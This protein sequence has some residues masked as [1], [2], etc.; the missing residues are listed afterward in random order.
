[1]DL[2]Q[3]RTFT[4]VARTG[5]IS[6]AAAQLGYS[7][8]ALSRQIQALEND[9]GVPLLDRVARGIRLTRH[10]EA[11]LPYAREV[12]RTLAQARVAVAEASDS[13]VRVRLGSVPS[14][15]ASLVVPAL[16]LLERAEP[17][18]LVDLRQG[19]AAAL[20]GAVLA[21]E[22]DAAVILAA[23][24]SRPRAGLTVERVL[25]DELRLLV[26]AGH[27]SAE[28]GVPVAL[29]ELA[30]QAW[31]ETDGDLGLLHRVGAEAGLRLPR[32]RPVPDHAARIAYVAGGL[33]L[34][35]IPGLLA[36]DLPAGLV[37]VALRDAPRRD[38]VWIRR[39]GRSA[40]GLDELGAAL[41]QVAGGTRP[42]RSG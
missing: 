42:G 39:V 2:A 8:S 18:V 36:V 29:A 25:T 11:L 28:S 32:V 31:V 16:A 9:L 4:V 5:S 6:R 12:L 19:S 30:D 14:A 1:M 33:G 34:S 35:L 3:L 21:E 40:P 27:P 37:A 22:L 7:Q 26:P 24:E 20:I 10:G 15:T 13:A 38:L 17:A 41:A 23:P